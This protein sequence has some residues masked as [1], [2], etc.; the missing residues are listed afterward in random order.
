MKE[1]GVIRTETLATL[2]AIT[3]VY[4]IESLLDTCTLLLDEIYRS[5]LTH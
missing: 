1:V 3:L 4:N 5:P 2:P